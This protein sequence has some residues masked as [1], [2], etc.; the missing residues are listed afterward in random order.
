MQAGKNTLILVAVNQG[1]AD[2][3]MATA[4]AAGARGGTSIRGRWVGAENFEE[5]FPTMHGGEREILAIVAPNE[6]ARAILDAV[7][8]KHGMQTKAGAVIC[9]VGIERMAHLR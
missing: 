3:V 2:E 7:N 8:E 1:F 5:N 4:R 9:S 6:P